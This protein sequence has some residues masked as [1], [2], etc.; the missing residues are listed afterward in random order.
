MEKNK[1]YE[2]ICCLYNN[3]PKSF[4]VRWI[5]E[6]GLEAPKSFHSKGERLELPIKLAWIGQFEPRVKRDDNNPEF[7]SW[8]RKHKIPDFDQFFTYLTGRSGV[9]SPH[10]P[11]TTIVRPLCAFVQSIYPP[12]PETVNHF[13][14]LQIASGSFANQIVPFESDDTYIFGQ[15][16]GN[17]GDLSQIFVAGEEVNAF[18]S[19]SSV[20]DAIHILILTLLPVSRCFLLRLMYRRHKIIGPL[21]FV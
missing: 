15:T 13:G 6:A 12:T 4:I 16:M 19:G 17:V 7:M 21:L 2:E 9:A 14:L 10:F 20:N 8:L 11:V 3:V 5:K 18:L 1:S